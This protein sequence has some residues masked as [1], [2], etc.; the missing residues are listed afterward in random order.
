MTEKLFLLQDEKYGD[1]C[2]ALMPTVDRDRVIGVRIPQIRA[3]A[4]KIY[5]T[6]QAELFIS[7]LPHRYYEENNLHAFIIEKEK[8]FKRAVMLTEEFLPHIDNWATCD[9]F[10][11]IAF[12]SNKDRLLPYIK[13]WL[14]S[15]KTYTVRF[16]IEMLMKHYLDDGFSDEMPHLVLDATNDEYYVKMMAAWY[17]ATALA[18]RYDDI[19]GYIEK[20]LPDIWVHNKTIQK[21]TESYRISDEKKRYL[22]TLKR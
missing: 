4:K 3:L 13:R 17:F 15:D 1:F 18:K 14:G 10:S 7:E 20:G 21:A 2:A 5:G 22:K 11:P 19:I 12:K 9:S 16:A 6:R 8:N